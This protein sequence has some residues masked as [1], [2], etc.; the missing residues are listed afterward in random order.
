MACQALHQ[1]LGESP[2]EP[3]HPPPVREIDKVIPYQRHLKTSF[4]RQD[5]GITQPESEAPIRSAN[6]KSL[7]RV[8]GVPEKAAERLG[9]ELLPEGLSRQEPPSAEE[10]PLPEDAIHL[11]E[12]VGTCDFLND[13]HYTWQTLASDLA[14][15]EGC[16]AAEGLP[17]VAEPL[18]CPPEGAFF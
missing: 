1:L 17:F 13:H 8:F 4:P 15:A 2:S 6:L 3:S 5:T 11:C 12:D 16:L 7:E 14:S 10:V 18:E 9:E